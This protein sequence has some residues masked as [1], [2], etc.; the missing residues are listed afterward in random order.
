MKGNC[1]I[2]KRD[3]AVC[4]GR[5]CPEKGFHLAMDAASG[6]ALPL[7]L[8]GEVA[9]YPEHRRYFEGKIQP[10]LGNLH[11]WLGAIS[12]ERKRYLMAGARAV[13]IPSLVPETSSLV[14]MEAIASGTPVIA[15][16]QGALSEIVIHGKTGFLVNTVNEMRDAILAADE[17]DPGHCV[18][19]AKMRF[20]A[21][22]MV[23][24]YMQLYREAAL[25]Q[26]EAQAELGKAA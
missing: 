15:Y 13:L 14:A 5:I 8:A 2:R 17:I 23:E 12:G 22:R 19:E 1:A 10:R 24:S 26:G 18:R 9:A 21:A 16:P 11:R 4:L 25:G 20:S 6:C 7:Y 3:F